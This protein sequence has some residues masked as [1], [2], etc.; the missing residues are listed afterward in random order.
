M[1]AV[2]LYGFGHTVGR[3]LIH[4][5]R[6][7]RV[8]LAIHGVILLGWMLFFVVQSLLVRVRNIRLHRRLGWFGAADG[9][10]VIL[11][12][13]AITIETNAPAALQRVGA[14]SVLGFGIPFSLAILWRRRPEFHRRLLLIATAVLTNA[15]FARFPSAFDPN[16]LFF[17]GTDLFILAGMT[18][19]LFAGQRIHNVYRYGAPIL[20]AAQVAVLIP[21]WRYL[22]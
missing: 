13:I 14:V 17:A 15:A 7:H 5:D 20:F 2:V 18:H 19:D 6:P 22:S 16:H 8:F 10:L 11:S 1:L 3:N 4:S 9:A 21:A 12:L